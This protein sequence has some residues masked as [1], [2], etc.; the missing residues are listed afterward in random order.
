MFEVDIL[1]LLL[2]FAFILFDS[3]GGIEFGIRSSLTKTVDLLS[4]KFS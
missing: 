1:V 3:I 2:K 4:F